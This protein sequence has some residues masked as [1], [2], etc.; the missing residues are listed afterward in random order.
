MATLNDIRSSYWQLSTTQAGEVVQ[1]IEDIKQCIQT[2]LTTQRGT[3]VLNPNLG[4]DLMA[5]IG[6]P[7]NT[8]EA[9][10]TREIIEQITEF[11]PRATIEK[12]IPSLSGDGSNLII[13]LTWSSEVG[14][15]TNNV[16]YAIST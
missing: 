2:I 6:Q 9:D 13:E 7:I 14:T 10:L 1:G 3:V 8:V 5:F 4:L 12:I 16:Q 11:E 15:G